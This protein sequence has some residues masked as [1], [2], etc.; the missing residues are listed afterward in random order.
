MAEHRSTSHK[1]NFVFVA[2]IRLKDF[3]NFTITRIRNKHGQKMLKTLLETK[4]YYKFYRNLGQ[5][6]DIRIKSP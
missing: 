3:E 4:G 5:L 2:D 6:A 1:E